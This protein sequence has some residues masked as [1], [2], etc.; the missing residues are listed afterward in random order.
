MT[1]TTNTNTGSRLW[2]SW[3]LKSVLRAREPPVA[4]V[5]CGKAPKV[6]GTI[7]SPI[8]VIAVTAVVSWSRPAT[9]N[10]IFRTCCAG[11]GVTWTGPSPRAPAAAAWVLKAST[12]WATAG[13][14]TSG[15]FTTIMP[16][17]G[18]AGKSAL[19]SL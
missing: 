12:A 11:Y 1:E 2:S 15:V 5:V 17:A 3:R 19:I 10:R 16:G 4:A 18:L 9:G 7:V 13:E 8:F 6:C 14:P